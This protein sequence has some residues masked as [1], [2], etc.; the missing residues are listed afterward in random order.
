MFNN[1]A[2]REQNATMLFCFSVYDTNQI[3]ILNVFA[4]CKRN[5]TRVLS[6]S[7]T[8]YAFRSIS[9]VR[10]DFVDVRTVIAVRV[11]IVIV[12]KNKRSVE[13]SE[14]RLLR[15]RFDGF[16]TYDFNECC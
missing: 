11:A 1:A 16:A 7:S 9:D 4:S 13:K 15:F 14:I 10:L 6:R 5:N 3:G 2:F 12:L 8:I